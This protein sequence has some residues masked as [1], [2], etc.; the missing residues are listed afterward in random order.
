MVFNLLSGCGNQVLD[1][2]LKPNV[3]TAIEPYVTSLQEPGYFDSLG[4]RVTIVDTPTEPLS[5]NNVNVTLV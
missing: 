5:N 4:N 2:T 3:K 1:L